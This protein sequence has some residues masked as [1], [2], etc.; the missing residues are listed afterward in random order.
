MR[1]LN[2]IRKITRFDVWVSC[3]IAFSIF[4]VGDCYGHE[5]G[6]SDG[7]VLGNLV[8]YVDGMNDGEDICK[9]SDKENFIPP[10]PKVKNL[11]KGTL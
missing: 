9:G 4:S 2:F 6:H 8:G 1:V 11:Y 5:R 7:W 3:L 10:A